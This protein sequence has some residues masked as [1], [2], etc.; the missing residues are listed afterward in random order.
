MKSLRIL[1]WG[2]LFLAVKLNGE[3]WW[4]ETTQED[5]ADGQYDVGLYAAKI[6]V[7]DSGTVQ[8]TG[9]R[10][11][12][13]DGHMD[14]VISNNRTGDTSNINPKAYY[15]YRFDNL[16]RVDSLFSFNG[17]GN[18]V[19]DY[20]NDGYLD[21]ILSAYNDSLG[22]MNRYSRIYYGPAWARRDSFFTRGACG[23]SS[24]DLDAD[25]DLDLA[26]SN[27]AGYTLVRYQ[28]SSITDSLPCAYNFSNAIADFN[29]DGNLDIV[30]AGMNGRVFF[31]PD[32]DS[33][34]TVSSIDTLTDVSVADMNDDDTLDIIFS[35]IGASSYIVYG[36]GFSSMDSIR[37]VNTRGVS[38]A[39]LDNNAVLDIVFSTWF[40]PLVAGFDAPSVII[41]GPDYE[42][43]IPALLPTHGSIGNMIGDFTGDGNLDI[44]FCNWADGTASHEIYSYIF[45]GPAFASYDSVRTRGAHMSTTSDLGNVYN[46]EPLEDYVSSVYDA[47]RLAQ[48]DSVLYT[49]DMPASGSQFT[50]YVQTGDTADPDD[51]WSDWL[52][53]ASGDTLPDSL[54]SRYIRY[55]AEFETDYLDAPMLQDVSIG[56]PGITDVTPDS[57]LS[58]QP[59]D[60]DHFAT[61]ILLVQVVNL[62]EDATSFPVHC[63]L[64]SAGTTIFD[65]TRTVENLAADSAT[66]VYFGAIYFAPGETLRVI[67]EHPLDQAP[68][69]DT[70][71]AVLGPTAIEEPVLPADVGLEVLMQK[72]GIEFSYTLAEEGLV[73]LSL[74]DAA[75]RMVKVLD[76][77]S[78]TAGKHSVFWQGHDANGS[79][80]PCGVYFVRLATRNL[81][82]NRKIILAD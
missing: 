52:E 21:V 19:V 77:G 8:M 7:A 10:D 74:Y 54:A 40:D 47:G 75:G 4:T 49:V 41:Y 48:W 9:I 6:G 56:Y 11:I 5:F 43:S 27:L 81:T 30:L 65:S 36:P 3:L 60:V 64:D 61:Y 26:I 33:V 78:R 32:F 24:A 70:L 53:I 37:T 20:D 62:G 71:L 59:D 1:V 14:F 50:L 46:R 12:D 55:M 13:T 67:T 72:P 18:H 34:F 58:P 42:N 63:L 2:V 44:C 23:V 80:A 76:K 31:G 25:G 28:G 69:N 22:N 68:E 39:D 45:R 79:K 38:V 29:G 82:L 73:T 57:L 66:Q 16:V 15:A 35:A 17:S 51:T